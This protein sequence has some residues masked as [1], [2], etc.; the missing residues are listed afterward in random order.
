MTRYQVKKLIL[1]SDSVE[2]QPGDVVIRQG[3]TS[4]GMFVILDGAVDVLFEQAGG[5][6]TI[7][8]GGPGDIFGEVGFAGE[9]VARTA[10]VRATSRVTAIRM[11]ANRAQKGLRFYPGISTRVYRNI[12]AILGGRLLRSHQRL[13]DEQ[14]VKN[15]L[16]TH[17]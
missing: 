2:F 8:Q 1:L 16:D 13:M 4:P 15:R 11:D 17:Y 10:T 12:G 14:A 3:E 5:T 9:T 6:K 7:D